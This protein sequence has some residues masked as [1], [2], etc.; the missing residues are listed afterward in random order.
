[1]AIN[2]KQ[3]PSEANGGS[4]VKQGF[5]VYVDLQ[6]SN[7]RVQSETFTE[8][9]W[10]HFGN[11]VSAY[12]SSRRE[13]LGEFQKM[14]IDHPESWKRIERERDRIAALRK[15]FKGN[16][17][18]ESLMEDLNTARKAL[19]DVLWG[20][21]SEHEKEV[22][23]NRFINQKQRSARLEVLK[24]L[25][26]AKR[27]TEESEE[28]TRKREETEGFKAG[29]MYFKKWGNAWEGHSH[30]N[31]E[32]T[33]PNQKLSIQK[34]LDPKNAKNPLA[35]KPR[36]DELRYF[37]FPANNMEWIEK[38]MNILICGDS[39]IFDS[40][41]QTGKIL[42]RGFWR[43]QMY[44]SGERGITS[45]GTRHA[46]KMATGPI[47]TRH[48][49]S[50]CAVIPRGKLLY[51]EFREDTY[52]ILEMP[53]NPNLQLQDATRSVPDQSK[54]EGKDIAIFLPYLH[55]ETS[56][57]RAKMTEIVDEVIRPQGQK[58]VDDQNMADIVENK[59]K[60]TGKRP[61]YRHYIGN[62][63]IAIA[64]VAEEMDYED[65]E[66]LLRESISAKAPL[67]ARRTLDQY[68]FPTLEDTSM[69][70]R[71]QVVYRGTKYGSPRVVMVDQL[72]LWIMNDNDGE[73]TNQTH[74]ASTRVY[75]C[76]L[77]RK[78]LA[79]YTI[80]CSRVFFDR[81]KPL[82]QRPEVMDLFAS[83]IGQVTEQTTVAY[84][85]FW[86]NLSIESSI[87]PSVDGNISHHRR[88]DI[89]PE[90]VI[91]QEAQDIAEEL[92]MMGQV[93]TDQWKVTKDLRRY[94]RYPEGEGIEQPRE[95]AALEKLIVRL[96]NQRDS[97]K[98]HFQ[99]TSVEKAHNPASQ[100]AI[101]L[102]SAA[103]EAEV[104]LENIED[105]RAEIQDLE[106]SALRICQQLEGLLSL[107]QQQA[108]IV[109][110]K[111]ALLRAD[112]S[113]K[114]GRAI[115]AF[116]L[117]TIFFLPLGFVAT[118]FGM[119]NRE[120]NGADWLSLDEQIR[121]MFIVTIATVII[122]V[123]VAFSAWPRAA[124]RLLVHVPFVWFGEHTGLYKY[125]KASPVHHEKLERRASRFLGEAERRKL[126]RKHPSNINH[127]RITRSYNNSMAR[128]DKETTPRNSWR[129]RL[130]ISKQ[131]P[132]TAATV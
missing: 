20:N 54:N 131:V 25:K 52:L 119:N 64:K 24:R 6:Y 62:Y 63:L 36:G 80:S 60:P 59:R 35:H 39:A 55:W 41:A 125:W 121:Y 118:F 53:A 107:K 117:V 130:G 40:T 7:G 13:K 100:T 9:P 123:S 67:H 42:A 86:H 128:E 57:R 14:E 21:I 26:C 47:H 120:I 28:V 122:I 33:Y 127:D 11:P 70:D 51:Q 12:L 114:Q 19:R 30:E 106:S 108:S 37:H 22:K 2:G 3:K 104:L 65:D 126:K 83:A 96:L 78:R 129:D 18:K 49:R 71:D 85:S 132:E 105:R 69:R 50:R 102:Q 44:G 31:C 32:E 90:G 124:V 88:L 92:R 4:I 98:Q 84:E 8:E 15:R 46:K 48:M 72:W 97:V 81:T 93:F 103:Y 23:N 111:A 16:E 68:Y 10:K 77:N 82:D 75:G 45:H 29:V 17:L 79:L 27:P 115:M 89:N 38:A 66:H 116:T 34:I 95:L 101:N 43:G 113:Y 76:A 94:L 87:N 74:P 109:E 91:L 73:E 61:E 5:D 110:A 112:E 99:E 58:K 56:S 1:M